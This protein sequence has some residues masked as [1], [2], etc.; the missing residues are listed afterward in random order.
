MIWRSQLKASGRLQQ[1]MSIGHHFGQFE[2]SSRQ[3]Y[4]PVFWVQFVGNCSPGFR[5][6]TQS[7]HRRA[8]YAMLPYCPSGV[9]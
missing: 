8:G 6:Y 1:G 4:R 3:W 7:G 9:R 2:F 5:H